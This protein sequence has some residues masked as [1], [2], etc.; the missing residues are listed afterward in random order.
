MQLHSDLSRP[1]AVDGA[2]LDWV[3]SPTAGVERRMLERDGG[4]VARAT[5]IVRYAPGSSFPAHTHG[6]GEEFVVLEGVFSDESGDFPTGY[7]VRNPPGS[8]HAPSSRPG[9]VIFVK[10]RQMPPEDRA[11]VRLD[12]RDTRLWRREGA[13]LETAELFDAPWEHVVMQRFAP[14][15]AERRRSWPRGVEF[16]V[17]AGELVVDGVPRRAGAWLRFPAASTVSLA[18][19]RGALVYRKSGHLG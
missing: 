13:D 1:A 18:S 4:E 8:S 7:Y 14:G 2:A 5:S 6:A 17:V 19:E 3:P 9:A 15:C 16:Y 10:L 12:T 11:S